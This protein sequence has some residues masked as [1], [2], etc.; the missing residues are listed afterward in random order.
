GGGDGWGC[1]CNSAV[2][3]RVPRRPA[4]GRRSG[5]QA[6]RHG[7]NLASCSRLTVSRKA[8]PMLDRSLSSRRQF[9][10]RA[11]AALATAPLA[12][13]A[14]AQT[15]LRDVTFRLDWVYQGPNAGFMMAQEKGFY[16]EAGLNVDMRPGQGSG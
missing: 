5:Q 6:A 14:L 12:R 13:P 10:R 2:L 1:A 16:K 11:G 8:P 9:L 7:P 15:K 4:P 3:G